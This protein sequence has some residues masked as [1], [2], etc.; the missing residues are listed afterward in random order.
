MHQDAMAFG[1]RACKRCMQ[2]ETRARL[3]L[4]PPCRSSPPTLT[5]SSMEPVMSLSSVGHVTA[6]ILSSWAEVFR[7]VSYLCEAHMHHSAKERMRA[8]QKS[9]A[10]C[11]DQPGALVCGHRGKGGSAV[12]AHISDG[13]SFVFVLSFGGN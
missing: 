13:G 7:E 12:R 11:A 10:Q 3:A 5:V 8:A 9:Q 1:W 6:H 4:D 2:H